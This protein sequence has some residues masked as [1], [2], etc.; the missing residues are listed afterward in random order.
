MHWRESTVSCKNVEQKGFIHLG[1]WQTT[2]EFESETYSCQVG[3]RGGVGVND[4]IV[5]KGNKMWKV[6]EIEHSTAY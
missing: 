4:N 1:L 2:F 3:E 5:G 6:P